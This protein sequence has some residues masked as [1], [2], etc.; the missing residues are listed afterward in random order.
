MRAARAH[1]HGMI[2]RLEVSAFCLA[3]VTNVGGIERNRF[4]EL[5]QQV[6]SLELAKKLKELGVKQE[7]LFHWQHH[8]SVG[9][10]GGVAWSLSNM[11]NGKSASAFTVAELGELI[12]VAMTNDFL[13]AY[14][15]VMDIGEED[16]GTVL[17]YMG[18]NLMT[19]PDIAAG[20]LIY[21]IENKLITT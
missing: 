21:L 16:T 5:K 20:M 15:N 4:M 17:A 8:R 7:S 3:P 13:K 10:P 14:C 9:S 1:P 18:H 11:P 6:C 19:Q 2:Q 12:K